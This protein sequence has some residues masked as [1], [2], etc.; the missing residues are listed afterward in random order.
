MTNH[1]THEESTARELAAALRREAHEA[2]TGPAPVEAVVRAG[3]ARRARR[4]AAAGAAVLAVLAV[5]ALLSAW[6][7]SPSPARPAP[8]ASAPSPPAPVPRLHTVTPYEPVPVAGDLRLALL[9]EG[10]QNYVLTSPESFAASLESSRSDRMG[11]SIRPRS[12]SGGHASSA[13]DGIQRAHGAW[14]LPEPPDRIELTAGGRT[15][16]A[17]LYTLPGEPG[18]G[19][20]VVDTRSLPRFTSYTVIAYDAKGLPFDT[21][22]AGA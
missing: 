20:Y 1:P 14:R 7:V 8:A 4:R 3:R 21:L 15:V 13:A 19:V 22:E 17:D 10:R 11:T 9:P 16:E 18:W 2:P 12:I 6:P 5:P